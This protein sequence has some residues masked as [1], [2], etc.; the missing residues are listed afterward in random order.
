MKATNV[1]TMLYTFRIP[2]TTPQRID[3][4]L[5][6]KTGL[7]R[8]V[9]VEKKNRAIPMMIR[10]EEPTVIMRRTAIEN[11]RASFSLMSEGRAEAEGTFERS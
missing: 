1:L 5:R 11:V 4:T 3:M 2:V 10:D 6:K 9:G 8:R 7:R